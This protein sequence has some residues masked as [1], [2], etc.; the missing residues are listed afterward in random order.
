MKLFL[1]VRG[2]SAAAAVVLLS[3]C[4][5]PDAD[6]KAKVPTGAEAVMYLDGAAVIHN[7]TVEKELRKNNKE[8]DEKLAAVSLK[9]EDL[10]G[11]FLFFGSFTGK[12]GGVAMQSK[13]GAAARLFD[14]IVKGF[15]DKKEKFTESVS[16]KQ[17]RVSLDRMSLIL[18]HENLLLLAV[19]KNEFAFYETPG[20]NPLLADL[21][22]KNMLSGAMSVKLPQEPNVDTATQM[23]PALKKLTIVTLNAP[24]SPDSFHLEIKLLFSDDKAPVEAFAALNMG[25]EMIARENPGILKNLDRKTDGKELRIDL[26]SAFFTE[27]AEAGRKARERARGLAAVAQLKQVGLACS[28]YADDHAGDFPDSLGA[29]A[30]KQYFLDTKSYIAPYDRTSVPFDGKTFA[31]KNTSYAYAGKG[32]NLTKVKHPSLTPL[33]FEKPWLTETDQIAVLYADGQVRKTPGSGRKTCA[34]FI[35]GLLNGVPSPEKEILLKNAAELDVLN[36]RGK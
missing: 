18:Y 34:E 36:G 28:M 8:L 16:G 25:L 12:W 30:G 7:K 23:V 27:I 31:E 10:A 2:L 3:G 14:A 6:F 24:A 13:D 26:N 11:R 9:K 19:E 1:S 15:K 35:A 20:K 29:L 17:R 22:F 5:D 21:D 33:A 4:G 32:V